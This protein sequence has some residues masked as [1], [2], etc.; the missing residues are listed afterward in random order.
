MNPARRDAQQTNSETSR[1]ERVAR[2]RRDIADGTYD[3]DEKLAA[4]VAAL[5]K[6][7]ARQEVDAVDPAPKHP[8]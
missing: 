7:I 6:Q 2:I 5:E 4:A 3:T 8:K 1:A